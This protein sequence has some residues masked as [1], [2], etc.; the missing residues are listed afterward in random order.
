M[1]QPITARLG[2]DMPNGV[3]LSAIWGGLN[4]S[5]GNYLAYGHCESHWPAPGNLRNLLI[6]G[7]FDGAVW[8]VWI[9]GSASGLSATSLGGVAL[10][11]GVDIPVVVGTR[12]VY[13]RSGPLKREWEGLPINASIE[14]ES[15]DDYTSAYCCGTSVS[16]NGAG[17]AFGV[18]G[19]SGTPAP[20]NTINVSA[21][22][23]QAARL[24][25]F[26]QFA[27]GAPDPSKGVRAT[28]WIDGVKQDGSG[29]TVDT[30]VEAYATAVGPFSAALDL[31]GVLIAS[32]KVAEVQLEPLGS[33]LTLE[34]NS[35]YGLAFRSNT[36]HYFNVCGSNQTYP[37]VIGGSYGSFPGAW[38]ALE[39]T[40]LGEFN[41][42]PYTSIQLTGMQQWYAFNSAPG[43]GVDA[44][45]TLTVNGGAPAN[46]PILNI[47]IGDRFNIDS[48]PSHV[49]TLVYG[50]YFSTKA[51]PTPGSPAQQFHWSY[52][53]RVTPAVIPLPP[54]CP[55]GLGLTAIAGPSG[56]DDT[57]VTAPLGV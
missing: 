22:S 2:G 57:V 19:M 18:Y 20:S 21:I 46:Q 45:V 56:C 7:D 52:A 50:D 1:I 31:T 41:S 28:L 35:G 17:G 36:A 47:A 24:V 27:L 51:V 10:F 38:A 32:G 55:A 26:G 39:Y 48:D 11:T 5:L 54:G 53:A 15:E 33:P 16:S 42:A 29:G 37:W 6:T 30:R 43:F 3:A 44:T 34:V 49:V 12:V 4:T 14:F 13:H 9:D 23:G 25:V 8:T 40:T